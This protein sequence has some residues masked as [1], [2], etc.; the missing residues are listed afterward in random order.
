MHKRKRAHGK[1]KA[2]PH[3]NKWIKFFDRFLL[4]VAIVSPLMVLP[5][6]L[7]IYVEH[8]TSGVSTL[9]WGLF[10]LFNIP[11]VGYGILHKDKPIA[12]GYSLWFVANLVVLIGALIY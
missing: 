8:D 1:L 6:I 11:W 12:I 9:T 2:Y 3:P 7:K 5:Q 10:A 4:F